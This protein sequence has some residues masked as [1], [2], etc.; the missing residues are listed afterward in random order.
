VVRAK[1]AL[2]AA[3]AALARTF[4][5]AP[6][7]GVVV[8]VH[9]DAGDTPMPSQVLVLLATLDQLQVRTKDLTEL[10]VVRVTE[11][12]PVVVTLDAL[13]GRSL[14]G[15]VVRVGWQAEDYRGDPAYPVI[16]ELDEDVPELRWGMTAMV[17][18]DTE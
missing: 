12:Q 9:V 15:H 18:I 13:P 7:D 1:A 6:F 8:E 4:V 17:E 3:E 5:R 11:G 2:A 14:V 10:D 16:V